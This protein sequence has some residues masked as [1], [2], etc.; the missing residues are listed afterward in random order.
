[1]ATSGKEWRKAREEGLP[2]V[3]PSGM[4]ANIRP[5]EVDFFLLAGKVPDI[6]APLVNQIIGGDRDYKIALPPSEQI[7]KH[8]EWVQFLRDLCT[9]AFIKPKVVDDPQGDDEISFED[10]AFVDK[11]AL[12]VKFANPAQRIKRFRQD[13]VEPVAALESTT[14]NGHTPV[15]TPEGR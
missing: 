10:I 12:F 9:Y 2:T 13:Q 4:E 6:L 5:V 14:S 3:F 11:Y 8:S 1:M 15:K 7:E